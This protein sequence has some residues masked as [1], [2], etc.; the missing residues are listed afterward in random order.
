MGSVEGVMYPNGGIVD[1]HVR[2]FIARTSTID[3]YYLGNIKN[4]VHGLADTI[5]Q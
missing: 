2:G 5:V 4:E 3:A 1:N